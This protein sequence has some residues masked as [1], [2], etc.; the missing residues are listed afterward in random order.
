[1]AFTEY[2]CDFTNGSNLNAGSTNS[3][4]VYTSAAGDS[5][6]TSVFTPNDGI[7]PSLTVSAGME[8]SV[9]VTA[10]AT[11][12]V[13]I[14]RI[15][16]VVNAVNGAITF[17]TTAKSGTFPAASAG[18]HTITLIVGG[19]WKGPN[20]AVGFPFGFITAAQTNV[21]G[22][23]PRVNF[24]AGTNYAIT[25]AMTH[26]LAGPVRF[27]G[28][29]T[30]AGD[31][32]KATIDGGTSG[33]SYVLLTLSGFVGCTLADLIFQN[34]GAS[35]AADG[36][37]IANGSAYR[38]VVHA[39]RGN[40]INDTS[41]SLLVECETYACNQSN[42]SGLAGIAVHRLARRCYS[43]DNTAGSNADGFFLSNGADLVG[44]I[45]DSNAGV[46]GRIATGS[47]VISVMGSD[48][49]NNT[50]DGLSIGGGSGT[51][52]EVYVEN[53]NFVKNGGYGIND[54]GSGAFRTEGAIVNCGFGSGTQVNTSGQTNN[55]SAMEV[56]GSVTYP[57]GVT[58]WNAPTTGDFRIILPQ[59]QYAGRGTFTETDGTNTGTVAYPDIGAAQHSL[60]S[61]GAAILF[62]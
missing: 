55:L 59:A 50:S 47:V 43:H 2:Y 41:A 18:A 15:V 33:V 3:A 22:D 57:S 34:N 46:G 61:A 29:T 36:L 24:K 23:Y 42:T 25:T 5:D 45:A 7:N 51:L 58:P 35:A 60:A 26:S 13:F 53:C 32:G 19:Y 14:G 37:K 20:A 17:S 39:V 52:M 1:M 56:S 48:F 28:M 21:A 49:Y 8:G 9:Y 4:P 27:Q 16:T 12:A 62:A 30:T 54:T 6:G 31:G 38:C 40:G 44:C 10:G 11:V